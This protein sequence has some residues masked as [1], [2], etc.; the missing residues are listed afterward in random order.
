MGGRPERSQSA[1]DPS[2]CARPEVGSRAALARQF[3]AI[4]MT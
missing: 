2:S 1:G 4:L 3:D